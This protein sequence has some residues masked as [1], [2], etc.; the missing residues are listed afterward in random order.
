MSA[1]TR[2]TYKSSAGSIAVDSLHKQV[3]GVANQLLALPQ[4][5]GEVEPM[6]ATQGSFRPYTSYSGTTHTGCAA[7]DI[8][9][10]N[11][12]NRLIILDLLGDDAFH[13]LSFEGDWPEH[14]HLAL[15]GMG[16]AASSLKAQNTEVKRGGDGLVGSK[17]D[18]DKALRSGLWSLAVYNGRTG[19]LKSD[20]NTN[21]YDG[22]SYERKRKV[23]APKGT[24]VTALME[25]NVAGERWFVTDHG[26]WGFSG[27]WSKVTILTPKPPVTTAISLTNWKLT[28]PTGTPGDPDEIKQPQLHTYSDPNFQRLGSSLLFTAATKGVSTENSFYPRS[29]LREMK[30]GGKDLAKW[31]SRSGVHQ[32]KA[33]LEVTNLPGRKPHIVC[34][35]IHDGSDD[36]VMARVEGNHFFVERDGQEI[37]TLDADFKLDVPFWLRISASK[38]GIRVAYKDVTVDIPGV[39]G[40]DWYFKMG[41]YTQAS[42]R[43]PT[44]NSRYGTGYGQVLLHRLEVTHT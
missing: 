43:V 20:Q 33:L 42:S 9:A 29:E 41:V 36:V 2:T 25:V 28:L 32:M 31:S 23:A 6:T 15:R 1:S 34:G 24:Q 14:L 26:L 7:V 3:L 22:P 16:C 13:R 27:K 40:I 30:N 37:D 44:S 21:L 18:R 5:G 38:G 10:Y 39:T 19:K 4:F 8:T 12:E 35:Q 17:P 11:W